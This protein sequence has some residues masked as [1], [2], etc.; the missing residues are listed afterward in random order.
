MQRY[1]RRLRRDG[2]WCQLRRS[3]SRPD[4]D[5]DR[6]RQFTGHCGQWSLVS[7]QW[8]NV[9]RPVST[10]QCLVVNVVSGQW[11]IPTGQWSLVSVYC[12]VHSSVSTGQCGQWS[13]VNVVCGQC[14]LVSVHRAVSAGQCGQWL[15][16]SVVSGQFSL[17]IG[18]CSLVSV[19]WS[20]VASQCSVV[21]VVNVVS[22]Q[23][24]AIHWSSSASCAR[25]RC[26]PSPTISAI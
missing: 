22:G 11:S 17:V 20:V 9:H 18:Q 24:S 21:I 6:L 10:G 16:V 15:M 2:S 1:G 5:A 4:P 19:H 14:S 26:A 3:D 8:V 12:S 7:G 23:C 13:M 25:K